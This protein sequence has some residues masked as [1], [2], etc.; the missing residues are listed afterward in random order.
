LATLRQKFNS[1]IAQLIPPI[2]VLVAERNELRAKLQQ[3]L[4]SVGQENT[5]LRTANNRL[6][7]LLAELNHQIGVRD[8]NIR[9]WRYSYTRFYWQARA[10]QLEL[11]G[12]PDSCPVPPKEIP[13]ALLSRFNMDGKVE[14]EY[15]YL[16]ATYP[17]NH[18][19]IYTDQEIDSYIGVISANLKK[20]EAERLDGWFIY[21]T[22]DQW[23]CDAIAKYPIQGKSVVNMGSLTPW[24]ESMFIFFGSKPVTI[25]YNRILLRTNRMVFMTIAEW[26][27][28]RPRF[29]VGFSISSFEHDGLGMYGDPLDP[30]GDLKAMQKMTER[31]V[32]GGL[33][34]LAVPTGR[35]K[36]LFNNARIYGRHR[37]PLL[38]EGWDWIDSYGF[39]DSDL[40]GNGSAQPLYILRNRAAN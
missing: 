31:I 34:F 26:E 27:R 11:F 14:I 3:L 22:L 25:D 10:L 15:N 36:I 4:E 21:G 17:G 1:K 23:V 28:D 29:D 24:Y 2:G 37:L 19:L 40:D 16:N 9:F 12:P 7:A 38:M 5:D 35:D 32:P 18:P 39:H 30:D 13:P 20:P 8:T 6:N 33:L